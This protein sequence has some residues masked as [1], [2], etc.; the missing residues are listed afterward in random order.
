MVFRS[1]AVASLWAALKLVLVLYVYLFNLAAAGPWF[2]MCMP[3]GLGVA[4]CTFVGIVYVW[5]SYPCVRTSTDVLSVCC[6]VYIDTDAYL[7]GFHI[8][9]R[10]YLYMFDNNNK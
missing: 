4:Q 7:C 10:M 3:W 6:V 5:Y 9:V 2:A 1:G 8:H